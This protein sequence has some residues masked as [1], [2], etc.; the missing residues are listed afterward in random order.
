VPSGGLSPDGMRWV[1]SKKKFFIRMEVL[2]RL[3]RGK[4]LYYL[5]KLYYSESLKFP[6][7]IKP[8]SRQTAFEKLLTELYGQE[9]VVYCKPPFNNV[10]TVIDYLEG[11]MKVRHYGILSNTRRVTP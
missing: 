7:K 6:G 1:S 4:L 9:W 5:K 11:F 8:L 3:F 2:S 10:E